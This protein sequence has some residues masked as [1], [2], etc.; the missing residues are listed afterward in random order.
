MKKHLLSIITTALVVV[1]LVLSIVIIFS[2]LPTT[3]KMNKMI[4]QICTALSLEL[5]SENEGKEE[6][7]KIED[8]EE[9]KLEEEMTINLKK[10]ADDGDHYAML[11]LTIVVNNKH[12]DYKKYVDSITTKE[13]L[14]KD[15]ARNVISG[16]SKED[17]E[18][19]PE[20]VQEAVLKELQDLFD[21][22]FIVKVAFGGLVFQ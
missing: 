3:S 9:I 16:F 12:E 10:G 13:S 18:S 1:N 21:S 11:T 8:L 17:F 4:T 7:Y 15:A 6:E 22:D 14:I 19:N 5:E 20:A 2:V